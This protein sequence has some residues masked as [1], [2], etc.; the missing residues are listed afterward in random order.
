MARYDQ[1]S[2]IADV[3]NMSFGPVGSK[4]QVQQLLTSTASKLLIPSFLDCF[5]KQESLMTFL[6]SSSKRGSWR[7][8]LEMVTLIRK[9]ECWCWNFDLVH[10]ILNVFSIPF[11]A[12]V[13]CRSS[14]HQ[15]SPTLSGTNAPSGRLPYIV[16][17][18]SFSTTL[19]M[20]CWP[21]S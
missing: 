1:K 7:Q 4:I 19:L 13:A 11:E 10:R 21:K 9:E 14:E 8:S 20:D 18:K 12:I 6:V 17:Q 2:G 16:T 5:W 15:E 3:V